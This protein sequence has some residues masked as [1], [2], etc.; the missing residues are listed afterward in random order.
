MEEILKLIHALSGFIVL[1]TGLAQIIMKKGGKAHRTIGQIYFWSWIPLIATGALIGSLLITFFGLLGFY[2]VFMGY[3]FGRKKSMSISVFDKAFIAT[4]TLGAFF[5][6][7]WGILIL[8]LKEN[9]TFGVVAIFFGAIFTLVTIQDFLEYI[10]NKKLRKL[11]GHK[12]EWYFEHFG[13]MYISFIAATTAFAVIQNI[14]FVE[15]LN[16]IL[17]TLIGTVL[18]IRTNKHYYKKFKLLDEK[19]P[20]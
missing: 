14:F 18:L 17:P 15:L 2:M 12:M 16:W 13:R 7:I 1:I 10:F 5:L 9:K 4:F 20:E 19:K 8:L 6:L 11:R 3:R